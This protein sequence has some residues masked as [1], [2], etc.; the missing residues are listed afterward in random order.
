[1]KKIV[2][3]ALVSGVMSTSA[4]AAGDVNPADADLI[5]STDDSQTMELAALSEQE[6]IET[7]GAFLEILSGGALGSIIG[8]IQDRV[9]DRIGS[10][11]ETLS[12]IREQGQARRALRR[13]FFA[14]RRASIRTYI[15][16]RLDLTSS[17]IRPQ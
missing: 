14:D 3:A 8:G 1:M 15:S 6:M 4:F 2:I 7:E 11:R 5:F 17:F 10:V 13:E 16:D 9:S 12:G